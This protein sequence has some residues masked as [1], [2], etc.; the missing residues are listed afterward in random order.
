MRRSWRGA[1]GAFATEE[2]AE[3]AIKAA[4]PRPKQ[5]Q[6]PRPKPPE[7][8]RWESLTDSIERQSRAERA[9]P[10]IGAVAPSGGRFGAW[11]GGD[12]VGAFDTVS[13]ARSA[14][15]VADRAKRK[16]KGK[17]TARAGARR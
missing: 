5:K 6:A 3:A 8:M 13:Q 17:A 9:R 1:I 11:V 7:D 16:G 15:F 2:E 4:P 14:V 10:A 12:L